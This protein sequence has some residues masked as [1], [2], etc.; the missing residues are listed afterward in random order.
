MKLYIVT[1]ARLDIKNIVVN[2]VASLYSHDW[3]S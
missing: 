1:N 2:I 3:S